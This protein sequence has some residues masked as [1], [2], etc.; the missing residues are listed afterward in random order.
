MFVKS[1]VPMVVAPIIAAHYAPHAQHILCQSSRHV[2]SRRDGFLKVTV[3]WCDFATAMAA[4]LTELKGVEKNAAPRPLHMVAQ[5]SATA[6]T[7]HPPMMCTLHIALMLH[8][9]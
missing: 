3:C 2:V 5:P 6:P 9:P 8:I 7:S 1:L 4:R